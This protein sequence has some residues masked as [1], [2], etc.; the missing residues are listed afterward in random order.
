MLDTPAFK[1]ATKTELALI[2][3]RRF[4]RRNGNKNNT[5]PV[6]YSDLRPS[7]IENEF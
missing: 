4:T 2:S 1:D 3:V 6:G 5:D 7:S